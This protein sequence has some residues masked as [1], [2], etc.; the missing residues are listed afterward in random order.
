MHLAAR[1]LSDVIRHLEIVQRI[2]IPKP[3]LGIPRKIVPTNINEKYFCPR[4]KEVSIYLDGVPTVIQVHWK[5]FLIADQ[6]HVLPQVAQSSRPCGKQG[7]FFGLEFFEAI[8]ALLDVN[9]AIDLVVCQVVDFVCISIL[10]SIPPLVELLELVNLL[11]KLLLLV[12]LNQILHHFKLIKYFSLF[13][14]TS[15]FFG[16]WQLIKLFISF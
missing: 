4:A 14:P 12:T 1:N 15:S 10:N 6:L 3:S 7:L 9:G 11:F 16:Q 8:G 2:K 13:P 5:H